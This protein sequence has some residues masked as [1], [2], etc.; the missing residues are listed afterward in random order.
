MIHAKAVSGAI[1]ECDAV[2]GAC[3]VGVDGVV[4]RL[5]GWITN[6]QNRSLSKGGPEREKERV[7]RELDVS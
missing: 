4:E 3:V 2:H 5:D 7:R 6:D 1:D